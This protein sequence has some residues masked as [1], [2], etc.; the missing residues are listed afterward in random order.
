MIAFWRRVGWM[1]AVGAWGMAGCASGPRLYIN[2]Q[3]DMAYYK[4]VAVIPFSNLSP[5][6]FAGE[7]VTRAFLTELI[8]LDRYQIVAPEEMRAALDKIGGLPGM[9]GIYEPQKLKDTATQLGATGIIR[10]AVTEY[11]TQRTGSGDYPILAFDV[12][13]IDVQT[14]NVVW[15]TSIAKK[16][17]GRSIL[18]GGSGTR[19]FGR[20]TQEACEEIVKRLGKEPL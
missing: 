3:A 2:P 14:F 10:G 7:R 18:L 17:K 11:Q 15:R 16:G 20:L 12:E 8:M 4:K 19:T 6:R 5:D 13:L 9:E 1:L